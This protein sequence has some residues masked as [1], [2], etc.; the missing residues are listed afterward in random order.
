MAE[1]TKQLASDVLDRIDM[2]TQNII[3]IVSDTHTTVEKHGEILNTIAETQKKYM[4]AIAKNT[5]HV[6]MNLRE[7]NKNNQKMVSLLSGK[8]QVPLS[9][10]LV[11]LASISIFTI[12]MFAAFTHYQLVID[13]GSAQITHNQTAK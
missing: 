1:S 8:K 9:V 10:F 2:N 13:E 11:I 5:K 6:A 4:G 12:M 7:Y 3:S